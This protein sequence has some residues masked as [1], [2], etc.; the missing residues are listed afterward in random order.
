[1]SSLYIV[2]LYLYGD[3]AGWHYTIQSS[4]MFLT[5]CFCIS[6]SIPVSYF[7]FPFHSI[8]FRIVRNCSD[9]TF[10]HKDQITCNLDFVGWMKGRN[11]VRSVLLCG[12]GS[13]VAADVVSQSISVCCF[14]EVVFLNSCCPRR[15]LYTIEPI[16]LFRFQFTFFKS[17][18]EDYRYMALLW[19]VRFV[20][21]HYIKAKTVFCIMNYF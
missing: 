15:W 21:D 6:L 11:Y 1:M 2:I 9:G 7:S 19:F 12:I 3:L 18:V 8:S 16:T 5:G 17:L 4:P 20:V 10:P 13:V 14:V